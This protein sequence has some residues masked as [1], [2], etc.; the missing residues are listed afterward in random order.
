M[1][2]NQIHQCK[3][4]VCQQGDSTHEQQIHHQINVI[5]NRLDE[6]QRRW[7]AAVEANRHGYG[8]VPLVNKITGLDEKT[9]RRGQKELALDLA[10]RP[11][12]RVRLPG[13]GRPLAEKKIRASNRN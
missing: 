6:Q 10:E 4:E 12:D 13:A 2:E 9:I 8:G 3:C 11:E 1:K 5:M 7:Y